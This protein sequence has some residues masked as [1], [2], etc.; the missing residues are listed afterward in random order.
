[1]CELRAPRGVPVGSG[2]YV[3]TSGRPGDV[4]RLI[5]VRTALSLHALQI[6][7]ESLLKRSGATRLDADD[8]GSYSRPPTSN[9]PLRYCASRERRADTRVW[10]VASGIG[11]PWSRSIG[12]PGA[13]SSRKRSTTFV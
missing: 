13:E 6:T 11:A 12:F 10:S 8:Q 5:S 9:G 4:G 1:M 2:R 3:I 7:C